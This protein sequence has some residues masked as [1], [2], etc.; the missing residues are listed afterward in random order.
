MK[1]L[2]GKLLATCGY[3]VRSTRYCP[4]QLFKPEHIRL[5]EF[6]DIVCRHMFE[7][8]K[9]MTFIQVGAFDGITVDPL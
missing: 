6:D 5:V 3:Q 7:F 4:R 8:G 2:I 9:Q 1:R